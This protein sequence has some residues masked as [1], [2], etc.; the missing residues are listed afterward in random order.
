MTVITVELLVTRVLGGKIT[1]MT[2]LHDE[3]CCNCL[4]HLS[5]GHRTK[6]AVVEDKK[7]NDA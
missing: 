7:K 1:H 2:L 3:T 5:K 4:E 6:V